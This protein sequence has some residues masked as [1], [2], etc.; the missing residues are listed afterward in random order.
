M[1]RGGI[2]PKMVVVIHGLTRQMKLSLLQHG[3]AAVAKNLQA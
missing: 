3:D 1:K 2:A